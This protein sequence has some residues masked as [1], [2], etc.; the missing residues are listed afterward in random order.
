MIRE[1]WTDWAYEG[2]YGGV[3]YFVICGGALVVPVD[4]N[5][6]HIYD[7][8]KELNILLNDLQR[9]KCVSQRVEVVQNIRDM[10]TIG[11]EEV[12]AS[13]AVW[14]FDMI[15]SDYVSPTREVREAAMRITN[16]HLQQNIERFGVEFENDVYS[17]QRRKIAHEICTALPTAVRS[18][19][20]VDNVMAALV[21]AKELLGI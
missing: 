5:H 17:E 3:G 6:R 9:E 15:V 7:C 21:Y 16:R 8:C 18:R 10:V 14:N 12:E 13:I 20:P 19:L 2:E 1:K 11:S 4:G